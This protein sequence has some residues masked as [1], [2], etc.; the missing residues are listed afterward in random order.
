MRFFSGSQIQRTALPRHDLKPLSLGSSS[1]KPL[2]AERWARIVWRPTSEVRAVLF[3][4]FVGARMDGEAVRP[5]AEPEP[6]GGGRDGEP[7]V[8]VGGRARSGGGL[9]ADQRWP[10]IEAGAFKP[11]STIARSSVE[12]LITVA[13]I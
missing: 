3:E 7:A 10:L 9:V 2:L 4:H 8:L 13:H 11:A 12:R 1:I 6:D 5:R